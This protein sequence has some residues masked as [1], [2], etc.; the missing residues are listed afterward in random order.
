MDDGRTELG[1]DEF[2]KLLGEIP[3][4][5][6]GNTHSEESGPKRVS[7]SYSM[8]PICVNSC[9]GPSTEKLE[10]N[11][12]I[13]EGKILVNMSQQS[14]MKRIQPQDAN[15]PD[16][17]SLTSAFAE[18]RFNG[19]MASPWATCNSSPNQAVLSESQYTNSIKELA[20]NVDS[21]L[22]VVSSFQPTN[23]VPCGFDLTKVKQESSN[24]VNLDIQE[25]KKMQ[26]GQC[27]PVENFSASLPLA[28]GVQ[29]F[30]F[31]SNVTVPGMEFP[32]MSDQQQYFAD[33]QSS[34]P[35]LH[36]QQLNQPHISWSNIEQEQFH[37]MHQ[38]YLYLQQLRNH[39]FESQHPVQL[40]RNI[41]PKL[42]SRNLRQP[43]FEMPNRIEQ[44]N[45]EPFWTNYAVPRGLNQSKPAF[46][47]T[48]CNAI[49]VLGKVG[50][51]SFP[52]K[53]LTRS[54]GLNTLKAVRFGAVGGNE[55][56]AHVNQNGKVSSNGHFRLN[57]PTP[58][59]G[60]FQLDGLNSWSLSSDSDDFKSTNLRPQP[61]KYNSVDEVTGRIYMLAKD[62]H[63]C[64]FLQRK[65]S[66]GTSED[67]EK[68]F[69][70]IIDHIV[71]LMTDPFGNYLVQKLLEVCNENQR[72]QM[73]HTITRK[74]GD[75][76]RI[77]CD[78]HG[79]RAVQKVI[80]TLKSPKQFSLVVSALK[81]G[82]VTLIKNMNGNH[83]AQR[84]LL[85]LIP[86]Y[87]K[88]LFEA[89]T[90]NCV[91][92]ATDRHG[93]C[94]LQKCLTHSEGEQRQRLVSEITSNALILSQ[95]PFG[96]YVVQF[97]FEL[98]LPWAMMDILDQLEGNFG[99]LSMQKYS[100]NVVEKCLKYA[101]E[102][103]RS[104]IIRE[105]IGNAHLD[106]LMQDPYGNY[107]I[108]AALQQSKGALHAALVDAIRPHIPVLRTSPY[109]KKV[110]SS[111]I[112]KK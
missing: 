74:A 17:Q 101:S 36:S 44:S 94:V 75:L 58:N 8:S 86:E 20:S 79:T 95:D 10:N 7:I 42:I 110:L 34:F 88:F 56:L 37:K 71:E 21:R 25:L 35:Y 15:L 18:L 31:L 38:Q 12:S 96:N 14:P 105:L 1:F 24:L 91:E 87:S 97:V 49:H 98:R 53:I 99:D 63:G 106:Q 90:G 3:N 92:L 69:V 83:V 47:S 66:E 57:L 23:T 77:S 62:Q 50:K 85:Y 104:R 81:P 48:E 82:I 93:C 54:Q 89:A 39:R 9:K 5:T 76:V 45:Q 111:N 30:Q 67:I 109:G 4:A 19:G 100:S 108:Q 16:D 46:S 41:P 22:M 32:V 112:L 102:E 64:R 43:C 28:H 70:E 103:H 107:V 52:E 61:Q 60:C 80:E 78:M 65:I 51:Q 13:D 68:I 33:A 26:D 84:C 2:E 59:A 40:S 72:M 73:L 6:S 11:G 27:Q 29:G 55:S